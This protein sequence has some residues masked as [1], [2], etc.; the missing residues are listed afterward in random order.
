MRHLI[1]KDLPMVPNRTVPIASARAIPGRGLQWAG[2]A[3]DCDI[4]STNRKAGSTV[5]SVAYAPFI[6]SVLANF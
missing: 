5:T 6:K 4:F 2:L 1:D 3:F